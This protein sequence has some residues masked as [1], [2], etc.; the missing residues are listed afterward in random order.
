[1]YMHLLVQINN[2]AGHSYQQMHTHT[3]THTHISNYIT[4]VPTCFGASAPS[5]GSF[6]IAFATVVKY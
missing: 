1:M 5:A 6:D 4:N 3:H 2:E